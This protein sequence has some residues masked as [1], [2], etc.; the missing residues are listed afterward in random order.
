[1]VITQTPYIDENGK[2]YPYLIKHFSDTGMYMLQVETGTEYA[3]A[4]DVLPCRYTY[5]ETEQAIKHI[6]DEQ[7]T[8]EVI[9]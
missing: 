5:E 3:E 8:E 2:E 7:G 9:E 4:V 6:P 1:M